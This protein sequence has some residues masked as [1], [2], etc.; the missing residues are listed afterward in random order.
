MENRSEILNLTPP[1]YVPFIKG[2]SLALWY[3]TQE[4]QFLALCPQ[5][6]SLVHY[7]T[8][9][10]AYREM[11]L[12]AGKCCQGCRARSSFEKSPG[13]IGPFLDFWCRTGRL[14]ESASWLEEIPRRGF[15]LWAR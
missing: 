8:A 9:G 1:R 3:D 4:K 14:P 10:V 13:L 2:R 7:R 12:S 15:N 11:V 6:K 5:C